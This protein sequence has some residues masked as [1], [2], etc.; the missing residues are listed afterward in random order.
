MAAQ[1]APRHLLLPPTHGL[2]T[3]PPPRPVAGAERGHSSTCR[4]LV[5]NGLE[6]GSRGRPGTLEAFLTDTPRMPGSQHAGMGPPQGEGEVSPS[7]GQKQSG[8][9]QW[10]GVGREADDGALHG[11]GL[12]KQGNEEGRGPSS[13]GPW[14]HAGRCPGLRSTAHLI[15]VPSRVYPTQ[16]PFSPHA[17]HS[18]RDES[19]RTPCSV[20]W[21]PGVGGNSER[22]ESK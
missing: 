20:Q 22:Q 18:V 8:R 7:L 11:V 2:R 6:S 1:R 13:L 15:T 4:R 12:D 9:R 10:R 21:N 14:P 5:Q 19:S 16:T 3:P 17:G